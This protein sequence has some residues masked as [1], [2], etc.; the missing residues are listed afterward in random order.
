MRPRDM[1]ITES[2]IDELTREAAATKVVLSRVPEDALTW[3][4]A[5]KSMT[6]GQLALHIAGLPL[7]ITELLRETTAEVPVVP[8]PEATSVDQILRQLEESVMVATERLSE[9]GDVGLNE[10]WTMVRSGEP[11][12]A[13][14]RVQ[15]IRS[16]MLNH[17]YHHR[18][19]L[20]VYLRLL[21][22]P[23]PPVYGPTAD[24]G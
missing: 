5:Q 2:L 16:I 24:E 19:Q 21:G 23:L 15:M 22:V 4:P 8:L 6:L 9:W 14:P 12:F 13:M 20:T 17:W 18:G 10:E 11:V 1:T 3:A 7:G